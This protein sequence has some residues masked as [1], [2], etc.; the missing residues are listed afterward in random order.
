MAAY[1]EALAGQPAPIEIGAARTKPGSMGA[2]SISYFSS[3]DYRS[4]QARTQR[5]YR[6]LIEPF[7]E[8]AD[9]DG[10]NFVGKRARAGP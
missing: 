3:V 10:N 5:V 4:T 2:L 6:G 1:E 7:C 8:Q 9:K